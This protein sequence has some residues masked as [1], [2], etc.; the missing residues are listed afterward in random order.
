LRVVVK[1]KPGSRRPGLS[2]NENTLVVAVLEPAIDGRANEAVIR[3]VAAWLNIPPRRVTLERG[4]GS[5]T[6][7][8]DISDLDG[9]TYAAA[10]GRL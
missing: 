5:R 1:V 6:K 8:L 9:D 4:A 3:A 2:R 7:R 10:L